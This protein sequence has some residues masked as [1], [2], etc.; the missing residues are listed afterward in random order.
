MVWGR[1]KVGTEEE[2]TEKGPL[3]FG[4]CGGKK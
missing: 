4:A 1:R 3:G 2:K